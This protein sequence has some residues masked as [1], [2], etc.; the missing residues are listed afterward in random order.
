MMVA[1]Y[2]VVALEQRDD[3]LITLERMV[4]E[5]LVRKVADEE[6]FVETR[7]VI[8]AQGTR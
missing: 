8:I 7:V 2:F 5:G 3:D 6:N 1:E 4:V